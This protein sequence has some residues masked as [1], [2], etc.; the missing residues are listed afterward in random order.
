MST[1]N[2]VTS[3]TAPNIIKGIEQHQKSQGDKRQGGEWKIYPEWLLS[4]GP[5]AALQHKQKH[6]FPWR[7]GFRNT[8]ENNRLRTVTHCIQKST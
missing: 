3:S 4:I 2:G 5:Q 1:Y 7:A 8:S 6:F